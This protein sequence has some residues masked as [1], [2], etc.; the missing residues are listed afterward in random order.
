MTEMCKCC[1]YWDDYNERC[2]AP[3][4]CPDK[5]RMINEELDELEDLKNDV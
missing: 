3:Y 5:D 4:W 1:S 2:F